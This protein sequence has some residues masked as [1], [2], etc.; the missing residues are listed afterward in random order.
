VTALDRGDLGRGLACL[1]ALLALLAPTAAHGLDRGKAERQIAR[2][3]D[4]ERDQHS[5]GA[6]RR[7]TA[8]DDAA[9]YHARN[10]AAMGFFSHIDPHGDGPSERVAMFSN[11]RW[12]V[13]E[14]IAGG[15]GNGAKACRTWM[16]SSGHR[17]AI[18]DPGYDAFGVGFASGGS[19]G[20]YYVQVFGER[21]G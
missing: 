14:N 11:R 5:V 10:M 17:A 4:R 12:L 21:R 8:L 2:C 16:N 1:L 3:V 15:Q 20:K 13:G 7:S 6:L 9:Q 18:L 19:L